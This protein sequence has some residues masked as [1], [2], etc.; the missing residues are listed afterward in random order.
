M[1]SYTIRQVRDG[2]WFVEQSFDLYRAELGIRMTVVRLPGGDLWLHSPVRFGEN[3]AAQLSEFG[4]VRHIVSP[5]KMHR[6]FV[7]DWL[8][9]FPA[10]THYVA[11]GMTLRA[12][13]AKLP[14][15]LGPSAPREW[16]GAIETQEL[17]GVPELNEIEFYHAPTR[18][19]ILTDLLFN[20]I[21]G[22]WWTRLFFT[23]NGAYGRPA[24][25]RVYRRFVKDPVA[26]R[27]SVERL[28]RWDYDRVVVS[29]GAVIE[30]DG[31][32]ALAAAMTRAGMPLRAP[33]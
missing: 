32:S 13:G 28:Q 30:R 12:P 9:A 31:K 14:T 8:A 25:T 5:S 16:G 6:L 15:T 18:T 7:L 2:M 10:A 19:L 29:H 4:P 11:A 23:L 24:L 26:F 17:L 21:E 1:V 22:D 33:D 27:G 3:L 20:I